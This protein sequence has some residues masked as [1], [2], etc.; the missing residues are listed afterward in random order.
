MKQGLD[1]SFVNDFDKGAFIP[2]KYKDQ[3]PKVID[4]RE[5]AVLEHAKEGQKNALGET[6]TDNDIVNPPVRIIVQF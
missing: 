2:Y 5:S 3:T 1:G 6:V 4:I